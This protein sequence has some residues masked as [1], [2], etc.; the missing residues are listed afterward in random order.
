MA[1]FGTNP[2]V[3]RL[4]GYH[5]ADRMS[6]MMIYGRDNTSAG[7]RVLDGIIDKICTGVFVPDAN[8]AGMSPDAVQSER[9]EQPGQNSV[10]AAEPELIDTSS[11]DFADESAPD[12][13][14][15]EMAEEQ[16]IGAWDGGVDIKLLPDGAVYYR[17]ALSRIIHLV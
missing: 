11:E 7:L 6:T 10:D 2:D 12:H 5:F 13:E 1:K 8:R 4:M 15:A 14:L 9:N 3:R 16:V 17:H